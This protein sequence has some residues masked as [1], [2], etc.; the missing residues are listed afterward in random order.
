MSSCSHRLLLPAAEVYHSYPWYCYLFA[1]AIFVTLTNQIHK[2]S[3]TYFGLPRWVV[4]LQDCHIIL[5]RKHHRIHHVAPHETYFCI[6]TGLFVSSKGFTGTFWRWEV[7]AVSHWML[8]FQVG[9]TTLWRRWVSGGAWKILSRVWR[10]RS[11]D[12]TTWNG[13]KKSSN[14]AG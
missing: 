10:E 9:W 13:L 1:L 11:P 6:T 7:W 8:S 3:H 4:F 2:W 12:Q 14:A 5:P